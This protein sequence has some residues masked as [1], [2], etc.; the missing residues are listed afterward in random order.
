M[1]NIKS[2]SVKQGLPIEGYLPLKLSF[3][4]RVS[5]QKILVQRTC[6]SAFKTQKI[7]DVGPILVLKHFLTSQKGV[8]SFRYFLSKLHTPNTIEIANAYAWPLQL[9]WD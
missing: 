1:Y 9:Q 8:H 5:I 7:P 4:W 6:L 2:I 3:E